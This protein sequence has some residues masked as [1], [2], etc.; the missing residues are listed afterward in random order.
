M[1]VLC[2]AA[3]PLGASV[4]QW[5]VQLAEQATESAISGVGHIAEETHRARGIAEAAIA[6]A[7]SV[8]GEVESRVASLAVQ[9]KASTTHIANALS[10]CVSEVMAQTE[11]KTPRAIGTMAQQLEREIEVVAISTATTSKQKTRSAVDGLRAAI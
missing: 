6:K 10:K 1:A 3:S 7:K 8:H 9:A 4:A 5:R 2:K 11:A